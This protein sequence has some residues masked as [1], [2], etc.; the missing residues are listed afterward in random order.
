MPIFLAHVTIAELGV[1]AGLFLAGAICGMACLWHVLR[2][3]RGR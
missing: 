3:E 1:A 2:L